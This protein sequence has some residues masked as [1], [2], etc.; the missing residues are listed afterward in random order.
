MKEEL[1]F[2]RYA[3][4]LLQLAVE[5]NDVTTYRKEVKCI[6]M[7]LKD[8]PDFMLLLNNVNL[9]LEEKFKI[10]DKIFSSILENIR[11]FIKIIIRNG[12][13]FYLYDIFKE[14]LFRFDDYLNI[15]E[16]VIYCTKDML[17]EDINKAIEA[18]EKKTGKHLELTKVIDNTL[19]GGFKI[20]IKD[21]LYDASLKTKLNS[22]KEQ[23]K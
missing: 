12:R 13:S 4:A 15:D 7:I 6:R 3:I 14:T 11:I 1:V 5:E 10:V 19:L 2:N 9:T 20:K 22:L 23:I 17:D 16:G 21:N 18:I 8:N